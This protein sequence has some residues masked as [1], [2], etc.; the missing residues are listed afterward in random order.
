MACGRYRV[1]YGALMKLKIK[2]SSMSGIRFIVWGLLFFSFRDVL[3]SVLVAGG[4]TYCCVHFALWAY[5]RVNA[6]EQFFELSEQGISCPKTMML[7][8][9]KTIVWR[10]IE[11]L[12]TRLQ[13]RLFQKPREVLVLRTR[14]QSISIE[15]ESLESV[16]DAESL[17]RMIQSFLRL[18]LEVEQL[19]R[20]NSERDRARAFNQRPTHLTNALIILIFGLFFVSLYINFT[21]P[22]LGALALFRLGAI[23]GGSDYEWYR[24]VM[25][26]ILH[27]NFVHILFNA[28]ALDFLGKSIERAVGGGI[29]FLVLMGSAT[30]AGAVSSVMHPGVVLVGISGGL[31][32]LLGGY[33]VMHLADQRS[34]PSSACIP[35]KSWVILIIVNSILPILV[36]EIDWIAHL[37]GFVVGLLL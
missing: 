17:L 33:L 24:L 30:I 37:G 25:T 18:N 13:R 21:S 20:L 19:A 14:W 35:L 31:F 5:K 22:E 36:P 32:G 9:R 34:M 10:S 28:L 1:G 23:I 29:M 12:G 4:V 11:S 6:S 27:A 15:I 3:H 7:A 8:P 26:V 2:I 16:T